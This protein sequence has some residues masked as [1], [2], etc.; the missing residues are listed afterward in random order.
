MSAGLYRAII[1]AAVSACLFA[2]DTNARMTRPGEK[3]PGGTAV[4]SC[5]TGASQKKFVCSL[6]GCHWVYLPAQQTC[7]VVRRGGAP[8]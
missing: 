2:A 5:T 3:P 1:G 8:S 7:T 4:T 6:S